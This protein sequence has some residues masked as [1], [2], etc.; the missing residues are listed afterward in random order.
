[1]CRIHPL[2]VSGW[3]GKVRK[4]NVFIELEECSSVHVTLLL[5]YSKERATG[6]PE[7]VAFDTVEGLKK[8]HARLMDDNIH[9][10]IMSSTGQ[11]ARSRIES[12]DD[13]SQI[14]FEF[15]K[16]MV[17]SAMLADLN[18]YSR[19]RKRRKEI[20]LV[21]SHPI[22]GAVAGCSLGLPTVLTLHGMVWKERA[23]VTDLY[24]RLAFEANIR[25]FQYVSEKLIK[26]IAISPY[27]IEEVDTFLMDNAIQREVIENPVADVFFSVNKDEGDGLLLYPAG[28]NRRKNQMG[29]IK[30][31]KILKDKG[32]A[33]HCVMPGPIGEPDYLVE[34]RNEIARCGLEKH[35]TIPGE[36]PF[37][38]LLRLYVQ[39]GVM[40]M[41][42]LQETA[43]MVISEAMAT[44]T[45]VV[46]PHISGIPYMVSHGETGFLVDPRKPED[47][48]GC[49]AVA[50]DDA[51]LRREMGNA[52]RRV[53]DSRWRNDIIVRR[54]LDMY[55]DTEAQLRPINTSR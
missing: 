31:L 42:T 12:G 3:M 28:I 6:G 47:I 35:V 38:E 45:P 37:S 48:A 1:M 4:V 34:I 50:L 46:A 7:G 22:S 13:F 20:D 43:P 5:D 18:Y 26:L 16:K 40:V 52:S 23:F 9:I 21:H 29:L 44:G 53:A 14:T 39:A 15:F 19:M 10:H 2:F 11:T 55:R 30:A 33:F 25:R 54:L 36:I 24:A 51:R 32:A 17:P 8:N 27:V 49:L 41:T